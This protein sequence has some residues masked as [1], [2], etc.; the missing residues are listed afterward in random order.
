MSWKVIYYKTLQGK[1]PVFEFIQ[2][3]EMKTRARI[4][5]TVD[6]LKEYGVN[7]GLPYSKKLT[8]TNLWEIR[9]LGSN[10]LRIFYVAVVGKTFLLLHGFKKKKQR[11]DLHEIKTAEARLR[12]FKS[13]KS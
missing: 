7:L 13:Q 3:F 1:S 2:G 12:E 8:G 6:L 9:V 10:N 11:T 5:D 4:F